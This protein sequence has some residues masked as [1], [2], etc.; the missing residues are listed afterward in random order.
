MCWQLSVDSLL[1]S[2]GIDGVVRPG[3]NLSPN[4]A[5]FVDLTISVDSA[6]LI[7]PELVLTGLNDNLCPC[8]DE[9]LVFTLDDSTNLGYSLLRNIEWS[10]E[11]QAFLPIPPPELTTAVPLL[12]MS[13]TLPPV[14]VSSSEIVSSS[15]SMNPTTTQIAQP[16][17]SSQSEQATQMLSPSASLSINSSTAN[18]SEAMTSSFDAQLTLSPS[19]S[20]SI[21]SSPV[22]EAV[23]VV[24]TSFDA[25][26]IASSSNIPLAPLSSSV[27]TATSSSIGVPNPDVSSS[28]YHF[29]SSV[30][31][32]TPSP[33]QRSPPSFN[34][35][36]YLDPYQGLSSQ[37][38][39]PLSIFNRSNI[40][41]IKVK[42][43]NVFG[44]VSETVQ[45][46]SFHYTCGPTTE[47]RRVAHTDVVYEAVQHFPSCWQENTNGS[48]EF[49]WSHSTTS[50]SIVGDV[51][52]TP[53]NMYTIKR[54]LLTPG[55]N[56]TVRLRVNESWSQEEPVEKTASFVI[57]ARPLV[58]RIFGKTISIGANATL[59][60]DSSQSSDP[61]NLAGSG[62]AE[63]KQ[64]QCM[65]TVDGSPC[66]WA[67]GTTIS[68]SSNNLELKLLNETFRMGKR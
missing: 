38:R 20:L 8:D 63:S 5:N 41:Q 37:L 55:T 42:A 15:S 16:P 12:D 48:Y 66:V 59:K 50:L 23:D 7:T 27:D 60:L 61:D 52:Q 25:Q 35:T 14:Y 62:V 51:P 44:R 26:Q 1:V 54:S 11:W 34:Y 10:V 46:I 2:P 67:N 65:D 31:P 68:S 39:L 56:Y 40:Y 9:Q 43:T 47:L 19:P 28:V 53:S 18:S 49:E 24:M 58:A 17:M 3:N 45:N 33:P 57:T 6:V 21:N 64:W 13:S 36:Q 32:T 30:I 4:V 22:T 29:S